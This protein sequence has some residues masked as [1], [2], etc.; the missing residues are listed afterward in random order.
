MAYA[1]DRPRS[2][3]IGEYGYEP[4]ANQTGI[5][6]PTFSSWYD[7]SAGGQYNYSYNP[8]KAEQIL[9]AAGFK[10]GSDGVFSHA[11]RAAA[12]LHHHQHRRL[13][14]LG[15]LAADHRAGARRRSASS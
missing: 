5:V 7:T 4:P 6:T 9:K 2:S 1:I 11:R 8:A 10:K 12:V 13:H 3:Q 15:R 14:R